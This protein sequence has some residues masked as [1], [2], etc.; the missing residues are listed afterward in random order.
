MFGQRARAARR[1]DA[2]GT[3]TRVPKRIA[4]SPPTRITS[5]NVCYTKLLRGLGPACEDQGGPKN[6]LVIGTAG[7]VAGVAVVAYWALR[8]GT[9]WPAPPPWNFRLQARVVGVASL[10]SLA[11]V[12]SAGA[13]NNFV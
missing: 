4:T 3:A 6:L 7:A 13:R 1:V 5:Y 8:T 9:A 11:R 10:A 12:G 2:Q